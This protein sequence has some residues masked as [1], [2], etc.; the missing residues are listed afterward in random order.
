M[1]RLGIRG[2]GCVIFRVC[3]SGDNELVF[4]LLSVAIV[5]LFHSTCNSLVVQ[6]SHA[7]CWH[8][9]LLAE[10]R[11]GTLRKAPQNQESEGLEMGYSLLRSSALSLCAFWF[12]GLSGCQCIELHACIRRS[13]SWPLCSGPHQLSKHMCCSVACARFGLTCLLVLLLS[14]SVNAPFHFCEEQSVA[15]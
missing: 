8:K 14:S 6:S 5:R 1:L 12:A 11:S 9:P 15:V 4:L 7:L 3:R 13:L 2:K 10:L